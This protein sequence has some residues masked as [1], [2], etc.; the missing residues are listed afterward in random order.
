MPESSCLRPHVGDG[1]GRNRG[2]RLY[3]DTGPNTPK[4]SLQGSESFGSHSRVIR[5]GWASRCRAH[6]QDTTR[7]V[8]S[9]L[10]GESIHVQEAAL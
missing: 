9:G 3:R 2:S 5:R 8:G 6:L 10:L 4:S 7:W 1:G